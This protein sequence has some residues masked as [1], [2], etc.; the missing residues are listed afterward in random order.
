MASPDDLT[1]G[2]TSLYAARK[3]VYPKRVDGPFRRLKWAIMAVTLA[4]YY[5]TPW[6]RWDRVPYAP[7]QGVLADPANRR[8]AMF[9]IEIWQ[10]EF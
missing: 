4:I 9:Q 1:G 3:A 2:K 8:F 7:G 6:I 5:G 10:T